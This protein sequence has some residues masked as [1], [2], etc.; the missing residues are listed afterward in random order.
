MALVSYSIEVFMVPDLAPS[1]DERAAAQGSAGAQGSAAA[2]ERAAAQGSAG[3]LPTHADVVIIGAGVM[4]TSAAYF[5]ASAGIRNIVVVDSGAVGQGSSAK[6]LGGIRA[7]F[8]DSANI[9]LGKHSLDE[10][11]RFEQDFGVDVGVDQVGYLF[12]V[13]NESDLQACENGVKL[14]NDLG[15]ASRMVTTAEAAQICPFIDPASIC[16]ASYSPEDGYAVPGRVVN[17][18]ADAARALGVRIHPHCAVEAIDTTAGQVTAVHTAGGEIKTPVVVCAAGAWSEK[19]GAM[20]GVALPVTPVKRQIGFTPQRS[21]P[22]PRVPFTLDLAST[23]YFHNNRNGML[24]GMSDNRQ[25]AGFDLEYSTEW[26]EPFRAV[27]AKCAPELADLEVVS[28]WAGLYEVTPDHNALI[29]RSDTVEGFIYATGFSGHGFLQAPGVGEL[30]RDLYLGR[31][32]FMD[33]SAFRAD[34]FQLQ[35]LVHETHII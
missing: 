32:S 6:P 30:V 33:A 28:G 20:A 22:F 29:G 23:L 27:A 2:P 18:Y 11:L 14:Q 10:Y 25:P 12:L 13:R 7:T 34:R 16:A 8:S 19:I 26:L 17:A 15:A 35:Q 31:E 24:F 5:L 9:E 4:G 1:D 21:T 3:A